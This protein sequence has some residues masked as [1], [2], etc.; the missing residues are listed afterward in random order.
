MN[1]HHKYGN[2]EW[3][4]LPIDRDL[5]QE[6]KGMLEAHF[7][8]YGNVEKA[9]TFINW[10][11]GLAW[12]YLEGR[13]KENPELLT[14]AE[15]L[16]QFAMAYRQIAWMMLEQ[17]KKTIR[18]G[19]VWGK[20]LIYSAQLADRT[21]Q[22]Y[23]KGYAEAT[24]TAAGAPSNPADL[25]KEEAAINAEFERLTPGSTAENGEVAEEEATVPATGT[26]GV[27]AG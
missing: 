25:A 21:A 11:P 3:K 10:K 13:I 4:E 16:L 26:M 15:P 1:Q 18:D 22:S 20:N 8:R 5:S 27:D 19:K 23:I 2:P 6:E 24:G 9:A 7:T 17:T 14:S 12:V